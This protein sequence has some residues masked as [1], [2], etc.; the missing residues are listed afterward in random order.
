MVSAPCS[1]AS[2][3]RN[4]SFRVLLPPVARPLQSSRFTHNCGPDSSLV[5]RGRCSRGVGQWP[6]W[7]LGIASN[8][9]G[10]INCCERDDINF[11]NFN[12]ENLIFCCCFLLRIC[13]YSVCIKL[14]QAQVLS[15]LVRPRVN[16]ASCYSFVILAAQGTAGRYVRQI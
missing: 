3:K 10:A 8:Q 5:R 7:T 6:S 2:A 1:M 11:P 4:S 9:G 12:V 16:L 15:A 13:D 14:L